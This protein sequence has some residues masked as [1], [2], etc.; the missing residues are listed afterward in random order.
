MYT[1]GS[2]HIRTWSGFEMKGVEEPPRRGVRFL[3]RQGAK[4]PRKPLLSKNFPIA[5][6]GLADRLSPARTFASIQMFLASWR[7]GGSTNLSWRL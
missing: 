2:W 3:N 5:S 4:A 7:L 6:V 1:T